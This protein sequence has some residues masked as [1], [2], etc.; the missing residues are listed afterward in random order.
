MIKKVCIIC[1]TSF[2]VSPCR[3][4]TAKFCSPRCNGIQNRKRKHSK[5]T[6]IK[7]SIA[8]KGSNHW[9]WKGGKIKTDEGYILVKKSKHPFCNKNGYIYEHRLIMEKLLKRY[10]TPEEVIHHKG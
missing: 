9:N 8:K 7:M 1:N 10:L 3:K 6:K 2:E 5:E 4:T